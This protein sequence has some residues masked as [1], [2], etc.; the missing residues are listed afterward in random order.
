MCSDNLVTLAVLY[1][2]LPVRLMVLKMRFPLLTTEAL[3]ALVWRNGGGRP[4]R[5]RWH[6]PRHCPHYCPW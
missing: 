1:E 6:Y 4:V 2:H 5:L 3:L